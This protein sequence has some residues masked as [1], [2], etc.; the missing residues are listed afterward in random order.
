MCLRSQITVKTTVCTENGKVG[1]VFCLSQIHEKNE[2]GY[3]QTPQGETPALKNCSSLS[4]NPV[5]PL[6]IFTNSLQLSPAKR[7]THKPNQ[8]LPSHQ[9]RAAMA[10]DPAVTVALLTHDVDPTNQAPEASPTP[11]TPPPQHNITLVVDE[12]PSKS[13]ASS[14]RGKQYKCGNCHELGHNQ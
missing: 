1:K 6:N 8:S 13:S 11:R 3:P 7:D 10:A 9:P 2:I 5:K 14:R 12:K 4:R